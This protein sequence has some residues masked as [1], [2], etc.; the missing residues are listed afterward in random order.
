MKLAEGGLARAM[1][2]SESGGAVQKIYKPRALA[3]YGDMWHQLATAGKDPEQR[4]QDWYRAAQRFK[5]AELAWQ[6]VES[7]VRATYASEERQ[8]RD[9]GS[10]ARH[11]ASR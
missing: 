5:E 10:E 7:S 9:R 1:A 8:V 6:A 11:E 2:I 3:W 4:K